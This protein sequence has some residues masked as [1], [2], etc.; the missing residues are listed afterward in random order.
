VI[1]AIAELA[2]QDGETGDRIKAV[3]R[4]LLRESGQRAE[5][6]AEFEETTVSGML[7][8]PAG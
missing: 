7:H 1:H 2:A 8:S 5:R 3:F 4:D 6:T